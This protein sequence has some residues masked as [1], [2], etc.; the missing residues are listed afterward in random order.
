MHYGKYIT[1]YEHN[2]SIN[3]NPEY[4]RLGFATAL[5]DFAELIYKLPY[6]P[7]D[8]LSQEMQGFVKNRFK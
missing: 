3:V 5:T 8:V 7:S 1:G 6:K 2:E 4:R